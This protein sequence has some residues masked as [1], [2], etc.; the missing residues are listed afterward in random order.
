MLLSKQKLSKMDYIG[1]LER[2]Q[3]I[4]HDGQYYIR[5][6]DA[7]FLAEEILKDN[8]KESLIAKSVI[9]VIEW[10]RED[11]ENLNHIIV[12]MD[13]VAA[14]LDE[15]EDRDDVLRLIDWMEDFQNKLSKAGLTN[16]KECS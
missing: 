15:G 8:E 14:D 12:L 10:T 6:K 7:K 3:S 13:V 5:L 11:Y 2:F 4:V 9:P 1:V 16:P